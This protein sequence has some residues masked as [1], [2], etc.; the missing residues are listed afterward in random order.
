MCVYAQPLA[1]QIAWM[2]QALLY[3]RRK[4]RKLLRE[5]KWSVGMQI[6]CTIT[7]RCVFMSYVDVVRKGEPENT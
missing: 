6:K 3:S 7:N 1:I 2:K 4:S 5:L